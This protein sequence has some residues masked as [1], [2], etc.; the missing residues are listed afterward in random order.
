MSICW[1]S[2]C[3]RSLLQAN[4]VS[5]KS[6]DP[7]RHQL[8]NCNGFLA[9][10]L[11]DWPPMSS[12]P[13]TVQ[14]NVEFR[15]VSFQYPTRPGALILRNLSFVANEGEFLG[16]VGETGVGKTTIFA[17]LLRLYEPT[18][19]QI[20]LVGRDL[21]EYNPLWLRNNIG[22][23]SQDLVLS[24]K[25]IRENLVYG[26]TG[27]LPGGVGAPEPSDEEARAALHIA[28]CEDTFLESPNAFPHH[29]HT[30]VG[31]G[32]SSLSGGERQRLG[33]ARAILKKPRLLLLDEATSA[34]DEISQSRL[35]AALEELRDLQAAHEKL[36]VICIAHRLSNLVRADRVIAV[37]G[38]TCVESGTTRE[39]LASSS[40]VFKDMHQ[41]HSKSILVGGE[42]GSADATT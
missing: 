14:W 12:M 30:E 21:R 17:L 27:C 19:G 35:Q 2:N 28:Q 16:I 10:R 34:L 15:G 29:W 18:E 42:S 1:K 36:T 31:D 33:L 6:S 41:L 32:G 9:L 22:Y 20:L 23:V 11:P 7:D 8:K 37:R 25:T 40:G 13:E 5:T 38:G 39:L 26:C 24:Q 4:C 3:A